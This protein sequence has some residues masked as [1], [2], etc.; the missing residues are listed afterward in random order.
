MH[1]VKREDRTDSADDAGG[2]YAGMGEFGVQAQQGHEHQKKENVRIHDIGEEAV[3]RGEMEFIEAVIFESEFYGFTVEALDFTAVQLV[4]EVGVVA[5]D[6]VNKMSRQ[7]FIFSECLRIGDGSFGEFWI[8][9]ALF[10]ETAKERR[11]IVIYFLAQDF[12][13]GN[14]KSAGEKNRR[15]RPGARAVR[16]FR[17]RRRSQIGRAHV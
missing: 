16:I 5:G 13:D 6:E 2:D 10:R 17:S 9:I 7:G 1:R 15:G 3:A 4:Q 11:G 8:A 14:G 12:V